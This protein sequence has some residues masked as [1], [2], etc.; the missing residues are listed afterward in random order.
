MT[1]SIITVGGIDEPR[2]PTDCICSVLGET[3]WVKPH[4]PSKQMSTQ[5]VGGHHNHRVAFISHPTPRVMCC[6]SPHGA[7][8]AVRRSIHRLSVP[9]HRRPLAAAVRRAATPALNGGS[10]SGGEPERPSGGRKR[11]TFSLLL[12]SHDSGSRTPLSE[13]QMKA[14]SGVCRDFSTADTVC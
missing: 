9:S 3:G 4:L 2:A 12:P 11:S 7:P 10:P 5:P 6:G 14:Y 1:L 8:T 13:N